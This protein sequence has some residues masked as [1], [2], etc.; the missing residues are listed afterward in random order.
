MDVAGFV[1][2]GQKGSSNWKQ[3]WAMYCT[4]YGGGVNDPSR[5]DQGFIIGFLDF[6]AGEGLR[7]LQG[8]GGGGP[9]M[10]RARMD[11][12][13]PRGG[14]GNGQEMKP[15]DWNCPNCGDLVFS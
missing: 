8:G 4:H 9:P 3:A 14:A 12:G 15:G 2:F 6:C 13:P 11:M 7:A 1:K 5:H 10:K